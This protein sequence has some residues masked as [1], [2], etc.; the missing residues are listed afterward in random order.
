MAQCTPWALVVI[1]AIATTLS[2]AALGDVDLDERCEPD[3]LAAS[4]YATVSP[5]RFWSNQLKEINEE[6]AAEQRWPEEQERLRR[7][8]RQVGAEAV[9]E[10]DRVMEEVYRQ[11]PQLRPSPAQQQAE[12]LRRMAD[13]L[14]PFS[15][16]PQ[17]VIV[18]S[19]RFR[20]SV[21][22]D[23]D[24]EL[25]DAIVWRTN[26]AI[27]PILEIFVGHIDQFRRQGYLPCCEAVVRGGEF[28]VLDLRWGSGRRRVG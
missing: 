10:A 24:I 12:T 8:A 22:V 25:A 14:D 17:P 27:D 9:A 13:Q 23:G 28:D 5:E 18:N 1:A 20:L 21:T 7:E 11:Y 6:L 16:L 3:G 2:Q 19:D 26:S 4:M 15:L